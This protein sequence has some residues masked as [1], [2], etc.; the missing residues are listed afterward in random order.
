MKIQQIDFFERIQEI[1]RSHTDSN[2]LICGERQVKYRELPEMILRL[3]NGMRSS[4]LK[5]GL[6]VALLMDNSIEYLLLL[7]AGFRL[8]SISVCINTRI[9]VDEMKK[10][11]QQTR[12]TILV[13][14][15]QYQEAADQ[16]K[17]SFSG[18]IICVNSSNNGLSSLSQ[19]WDSSPEEPDI[20]TPSPNDGAII[21]PTAA[22]GGIPKG[23]LLSQN[24]ILA[25]VLA[26]LVHFGEESM[27]GLLSLLPPYHVMGLCSAW[28]TLLSAGK[29][30][31]QRQFDAEDA[32]RILDAE[33]LTYF[34]S[35]PPI[36]ERVLDAAN[37]Q[38]SK[39]NSLKMVYGLE[40][41]QNIERLEK[42]TNARFWT[43]FGQAETSE[44][45]TFC[46]AS[47]HPGSAGIPTILNRVELFDD[48]GE[49]VPTGNEGEIAVKGSNVFLGYWEMSED[50]AYARRNGWHHTGDI[51]RFDENGRLYYVKRKAEKELIKTGGEN[52]YPGEVETILLTHPNIQACCVIGIPD[53][54]WGESVVAICH[55]QPETELTQEEIREF[56][57]SKIAGFKKPRKVI[58]AAELP[59]KDGETDR[60][61]VKKLYGS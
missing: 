26:H 17:E 46:K 44:F 2:A 4:G 11:I 51:G 35:F 45:I 13:Y 60:E 3:V 29:V 58:F 37:S 38:N 59:H 55:L 5:P 61:E 18:G 49:A 57:G 25:S 34:G 33:N 43:G 53:K 40:G 42:E 28:T 54:T 39:L 15:E 20:T 41:P 19:W 56:V 12:P 52:V 8:G 6:R 14:D 1:A 31:L 7:A 16:F 21:I 24:N 23:A 32:V 48:A 36:L 50:T 30:V 10:V 47:D 22:V 27:S 9:G